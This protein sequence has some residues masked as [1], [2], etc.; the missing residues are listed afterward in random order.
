[1]SI[2]VG[3]LLG[4]Y[5]IIS[6][7]GQGG[8]GQ[9]YKANDTRLGRLVAVKILPE[10]LAADAASLARFEQEAQA[11]SAL[12]HPHV[13]ALYDIGRAI[14][15]YQPFTSDDEC[16][17]QTDFLVMEFCDGDTLE[18]RLAKR[19]LRLEQVLTLAVE[20]AEGVDAAHRHGL[21]HCDLKPSNIMLTNAG[22][23]LLDFG[24]SQLLN[25]RLLAA[26]GSSPAT[27]SAGVDSTMDGPNGGTPRYM[28]P[29]QLEGRGVD[30][31][32]DIFALGAIF[33]E[34]AAGRKAFAHENRAEL[35]AAILEGDPPPISSNLPNREALRAFDR[36][37]RKCLA[38]DP[39]DRWQN[40]RDLA[41]ALKWIA[42][43]DI[44]R[45]TAQAVHQSR[46]R[47]VV[48]VFAACGAVVTAF[49]LVLM[50]DRAE[51]SAPQS[52]VFDVTPPRGTVLSATT[53][54]PL[55]SPDGRYLAF[56]ATGG[57]AGRR[58]WIK[59]LG[60]GDARALQGTEGA[61]NPFWAPH[62]R[63]IGFFV[64]NKLKTVGID[65]GAPTEV[66]DA[67]GPSRSGTW[68]RDDVILFSA[69]TAHGDNV[70][71]RVPA[72]GGVPVPITTLKD[73][74]TEWQHTAPEFLPDGRHYL[75][76]ALAAREKESA[77]IL[78]ALDSTRAERLLDV[79][80]QA[81]YAEPGFLLYRRGEM[82][83]AQPFDAAA[84]K[85][86]G[87]A[88][89]VANDVASSLADGRAIFSVS[90]TGVLIYRTVPDTLLEWVDRGGRTLGTIG[91]QRRDIDPAVSPD[92]T[93]VAVSRYDPIRNARNIW[94]LDAADGS[95]ARLTFE[96]SW[97]VTPL[98]SPDGTRI[99]YASGPAASTALGLF[100]KAVNGSGQGQR[101][102]TATGYPESWADDGRSLIYGDTIGRLWSI[103]Q[104]G[105]PTPLLDG[106]NGQLSP[107]GKWLA[108]ASTESGNSEVYIRPFP[109]HHGA[110]WQISS[111]GGVEPTWSANGDEL[112]YLAA[113]QRLMAVRVDADYGMAQPG[114]PVPLFKTRA[115]G[116]GNGRLVG[117]RQYVPAQDGQ[118][119]LINQV[120]TSLSSQLTVIV[121]WAAALRP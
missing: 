42:E 16:Q 76:L 107:D 39:A 28:A 23:K 70:I 66:C 61:T 119:F 11:M 2:R 18:T 112:Y 103:S 86:T 50:N 62:S 59:P 13:C 93:R 34:M 64:S 60:S 116:S 29:E 77:V 57:G 22:V 17:K 83:L 33:Y 80:S 4:R 100:Q 56:L 49:I 117:R 114:R 78:G 51:T 84:G 85:L 63:A 94:I 10:L 71:Q 88:R 1:M 90:Q 12:N 31:R 75:Y 91:V 46:S 25:H 36:V 106:R 72:S 118:R 58:I 82:L 97:D 115:D 96:D 65:G 5:E 19:P 32:A 9:V 68:S 81:V 3:A 40:A 44:R 41:T 7:L 104:A 15:S 21:I 48:S 27:D 105:A 92:G 45:R 109:E 110:R 43:D 87:P 67:T 26:D 53:A 121:N 74:A 37:V 14:A 95:G 108:Y 79:R 73:S 101:I 30:E 24:V 89:T 54:G 6:I 47:K 20:I 55:V 111:S 52:I 98:W 113:D 35:L 69:Q 102:G 99:I 38:R 120:S 8:M